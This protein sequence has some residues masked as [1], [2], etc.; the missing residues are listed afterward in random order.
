MPRIAG[1]DG[2]PGG[3]LCIVLDTDRNEF[4]GSIFRL[5]AELLAHDPFI[6]V[7]TIDMPIGLA[8]PDEGAAMSWPVTSSANVTSPYQTRPSGRRRGT[9][10]K[11]EW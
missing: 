3:W 6:Q 4:L 8:T 2:C 9:P 11:S 5:A 1:V 10:G 7:M